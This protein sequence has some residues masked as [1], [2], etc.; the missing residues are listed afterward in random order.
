ME[1]QHTVEVG[2]S[3]GGGRVGRAGRVGR[4]VVG[5]RCMVGMVGGEDM[6]GRA[7]V[8][9]V[10]REGMGEWLDGSTDC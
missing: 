5:D 4:C 2:G 6:V 9:W 10:D 8:A 1:G 3:K 7:L